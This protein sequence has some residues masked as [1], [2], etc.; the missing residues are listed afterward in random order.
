[1]SSPWKD[2][3]KKA[4]RKK[5]KQINKVLK[6]EKMKK[7]NDKQSKKVKKFNELKK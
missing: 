2:L 7:K 3:V 5:K 4:N 6:N 1:M